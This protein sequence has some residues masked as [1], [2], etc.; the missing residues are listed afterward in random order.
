MDKSLLEY[1]IYRPFSFLY[2]GAGILGFPILRS[3]CMFFIYI[4]FK[5]SLKWLY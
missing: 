1:Y 5:F 2:S 3:V 4:D